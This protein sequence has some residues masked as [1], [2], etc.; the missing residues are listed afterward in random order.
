LAAVQKAAAARV[1]QMLPGRPPRRL[2]EIGCGS[3]QLTRLLAKAC[4]GSRIDAIDHSP[5][6]IAWAKSS[7][8]GCGSVHWHVADLCEYRT[9]APYPW[10]VSSSALHWILPFDGAIAHVSRLLEQGGLLCFSVMLAGTFGELQA[11]RRRVA[12][13]KPPLACLPTRGEVRAALEAA[14]LSCEQDRQQEHEPRFPS[15]WSFLQSIRA[16]GLTGGDFAAS[17]TALT[18]GEIEKLVALYEADYG[19]GSGSVPATYRALFVRARKA[20]AA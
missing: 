1:V 11:A 2:L 20:G 13:R 9:Q 17:Q 8:E 10:I 12:P 7:A 5:E 15:A 16:Q 3:G 19:D 4:P 6:M 18:R 14:G